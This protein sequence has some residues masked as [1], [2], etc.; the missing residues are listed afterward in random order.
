MLLKVCL[1]FTFLSS[2]LLNDLKYF[3]QYLSGISLQFAVDR[4]PLETLG[5]E[6]NQVDGSSMYSRNSKAEMLCLGLLSS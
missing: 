6:A 3:S 1:P 4:K 2:Y 5:T